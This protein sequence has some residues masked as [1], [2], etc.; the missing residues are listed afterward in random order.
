[1]APARMAV[2]PVVAGASA[3][4]DGRAAG[5]PPDRSRGPR[6]ADH[7]HPARPA[8]LLYRCRREPSLG[9]RGARRY[10]WRDSIMLADEEAQI[11]PTKLDVVFIYMPDT[12]N[13]RNIYVAWEVSTSRWG[14]S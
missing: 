13:R 14:T 3:N 12:A 5:G 4:A 1:M 9:S 2:V 7:S 11:V 8:L 10:A 6:G